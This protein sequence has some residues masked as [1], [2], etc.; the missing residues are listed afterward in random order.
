MVAELRKPLPDRPNA[1]AALLK[2]ADAIAKHRRFKRDVGNTYRGVEAGGQKAG[3]PR[4]SR[5]V[6]LP[7][8][9]QASSARTVSSESG[10]DVTP[11]CGHVSSRNS[12]LVSQRTNWAYKPSRPTLLKEVTLS[13]GVTSSTCKVVI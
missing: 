3:Q 7:C 5:A 12:H 13:A 9:F 1:G 2:L 4:A 6:S 10:S 11:Q 8:E